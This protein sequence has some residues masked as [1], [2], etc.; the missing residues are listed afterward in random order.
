MEDIYI[1]NII[2]D[3]NQFV[4]SIGMS[5]VSTKSLIVL[6]FERVIIQF[7]LYSLIFIGD[8]S[9]LKDALSDTYEILSISVHL[10]VERNIK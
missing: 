7:S 9:N 4:I 8:G 10:L 5:D 3:L 1:L 6:T 2:Y